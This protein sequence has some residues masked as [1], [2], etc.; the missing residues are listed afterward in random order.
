MYKNCDSVS[1]PM[2]LTATI[3]FYRDTKGFDEPHFWAM[4]T[5]LNNPVHKVFFKIFFIVRLIIC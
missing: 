1:N 5:I 2:I 4:L 3:R